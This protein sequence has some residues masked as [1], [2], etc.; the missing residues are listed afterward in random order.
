VKAAAVT[1]ALRVLFGSVGGAAY[2]LTAADAALRAALP[3]SRRVGVVAVDGGS[4]TTAVA[5]GLSSLLARRRSGP[6]LAVDAAGGRAGLWHRTV[7]SDPQPA[8]ERAASAAERGRAQTIAQATGG[9]P[10]SATGAYVLDLAGPQRWPVAVSE[11]AQQ[12]SPIARFFDLVVTDWGVRPADVD[13]ATAAATSHVLVVVARADRRSATAAATALAALGEVGDTPAALLV[14][15]DVGRTADR[16]AGPLARA[17]GGPVQRLPWEPGWA[18][19]HLIPGRRFGA[20]TRRA[21]ID[22]AAAVVS[23]AV[24]SQQPAR[25]RSRPGPRTE[26]VA[27]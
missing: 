27:A 20:G 3:L 8:T 23:E 6:V 19:E 22:L 2:E 12:V 25:R 1:S 16:I 17:L 14:L 15:A 13:L 9:L 24:R 11:W 4:G 21:H 26:A 7:G 10:T 5:T 18:A